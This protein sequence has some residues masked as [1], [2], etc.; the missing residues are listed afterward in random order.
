MSAIIKTIN[1]KE[2]PRLAS[3]IEDREGLLCN[4]MKDIQRVL[5]KLLAVQSDLS[6]G[7]EPSGDYLVVAHAAQVLG[8]IANDMDV[9]SQE[10]FSA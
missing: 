7:D 4:Y 8:C 1:L 9:I 6:G 2:C 10:L 5:P 3:W